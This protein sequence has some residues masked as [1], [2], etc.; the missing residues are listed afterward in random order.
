MSSVVTSPE[1]VAKIQKEGLKS[2]AE[3]FYHW[4]KHSPN[5]V[6]LRQPSGSTWQE[7]TYAEVGRQAR[8]MAAYLQSLG[9]P[10]MSNIG[11][12]S[13]NCAHW[14]ISDIAIMMAGYVSVPFYPNLTAEQLRQV[15]EHSGCQVIFVGK[16][17]NLDALP[18]IPEGVQQIAYPISMAKHLAQWDELIADVAPLAE[19]HIPDIND[20]FTIIYTSGTTGT[21]KGVMLQHYQ[22]AAALETNLAF[23]HLQHS[24]NQ[25]FSYLPLCHIAER[26]IVE[27]FSIQCGGTINFVESIDSFAENLQATQPTHFLAVPR[28]WTKFQIG[29]LNKLP[30]KKLDLLLSIPLVSSLIKKKIKK[31]LGLSKARFIVTGAAPMPASLMA[32]YQKLGIRIQEVYGMTENNACCTIM[33]AEN[34]RIGTVGQAF[35]GVEIKIEPETGEICMRADWV[36][37]GYYKEPEKTAEVIDEEGWL[38]TGDMGELDKEGFLKITGR[39]KDTFKTAKAEFVVPGPIEW[40]FAANNFIEQICVVG[41]ILPQPV[42]LVVPS[43]LGLKISAQDLRAALQETLIKVNQDLVSHEKVEKVIVVKEA[44]T[45]ENGILTPTLKIKRNIL[46]ARYEASLQA[47][48]DSPERVIF[49]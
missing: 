42:A 29:I 3:K 31:G 48:Y 18:G 37:S 49:E 16:L 27:A 38:H 39:V 19:N 21:P 33:R 17:D 7:Y 26:C 47:W 40:G 4:E 24:D 23:L 35:P 12:I 6:Y 36:M 8:K 13:K 45:P 30:Q 11:I 2:I 41:R 46:E 5:K 44:W 14:I 32:W 1:K 28:I 20:L 34:I 25:F 22:P 43:E 10:Q 15:M 9:L